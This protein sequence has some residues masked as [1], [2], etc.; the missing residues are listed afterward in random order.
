MPSQRPIIGL[1]VLPRHTPSER[2]RSK[3]R[4]KPRACPGLL[5]FTATSAESGRAVDRLHV[6]GAR[7]LLALDHFELH[8]GALLERPVALGLD[9]RVVHEQILARVRRDE[10]EAL[11]V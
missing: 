2:E 8:L 6:L 9:V 1:V 4:K 5:S 10:A 11:G 7:A 3:E